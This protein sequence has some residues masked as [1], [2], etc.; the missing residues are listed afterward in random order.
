M[1]LR[2]VFTF[3]TLVSLVSMSGQDLSPEALLFRGKVASSY[4]YMKYTGIYYA[5]SMEYKEGILKYNHKLYE[6]VHLN[7]NAH[8]GEMCVDNGNGM[9]PI[10]LNEKY[11][12]YCEFDGKKF[13]YLTGVE[14]LED[15]YYQVLF[16]NSE[17]VLYKRIIKHYEARD[18]NKEF[19]EK[20][21]YHFYKGDQYRQLKTKYQLF[22]FYPEY[23]NLRYKE[24][25]TME[26]DLVVILGKIYNVEGVR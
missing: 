16:E 21:S 8:K 5:Y 2:L 25:G 22:K 18:V 23:K 24:Q 26:G 12:E 15:G 11:F 9:Q 10:V 3:L 19:I 7:Y 14:P 17:A 1:R 13:V 4:P 20:V 6:G